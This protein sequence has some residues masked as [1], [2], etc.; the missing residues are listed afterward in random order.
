MSRNACENRCNGN[1]FHSGHRKQNSRLLNEVQQC[2]PQWGVQATER[3]CVSARWRSFTP[4]SSRLRNEVKQWKPQWGFQ[5]TERSCVSK[6]EGLRPDKFAFALATNTP[7]GCLSDRTFLR[8]QNGGAVPRQVRVW[9]ISKASPR[10]DEG[11]PPYRSFV[12]LHRNI[13]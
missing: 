6:M 10:R 1:D 13:K 9:A 7:A 11:I 12:C 2:T 4:T 8:K 3:S 5:A